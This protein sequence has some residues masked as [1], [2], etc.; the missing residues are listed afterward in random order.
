MGKSTVAGWL[1]AQDVAIIDTD[2]IAR[3]LTAPGQDAL[4]EIRATFGASVFAPDGQLSRPE[5]AAVVFADARARERLQAILHPRI[6]AIWNQGVKRWREQGIAAGVVVIPLLFE[7]DAAGAFDTTIC[8]ACSAETQRERLHARGW[9]AAQIAARNSAQWSIERKMAL[10]DVVIWNDGP[11]DALMAQLRRVPGLVS[12]AA[13]E[14][15][16]RAN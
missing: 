16:T 9:T 1:A 12:A 8:V 10:A 14:G 6:R 7:T 5:L 13:S 15:A 3:E 2:Q 11:I 4:A